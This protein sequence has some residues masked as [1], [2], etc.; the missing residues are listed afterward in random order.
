VESNTGS[1]II[2]V[3]Y[4]K[5]ELM[6]HYSTDQFVTYAVVDLDAI[7]HNVQALRKHVGPQVDIFA[8]V[9]AQAYGH[10]AVQVSRVAVENGADRL[11]VGRLDEGIELRQAGIHAL[12][13]VMSYAVPAETE[14]MVEHDLIPTINTAEGAQAYANRAAALGKTATI[15]VKVDTG[16]GRYGVMPE[17]VV[18]FLNYLSDLPGLV[19]EGL[20]THFATADATDK[21]YAHQQFARFLDIIEAVRLAG[22]NIPIYHSANSAG[23][24]DLPDM[25]LDAVRPGL[26]VYGMYPSVEVKRDVP[27]KPALSLKS[28]V[29]RVRTLPKGSSVGYGRTFVTSRPTPIAL[30]LV[31][32]GDGYHRILSNRGHVLIRGQR[33][34]IVG[35]VCMDQFMV[36]ASGIKGVTQDDEV[37]LL[38]E[39]GEAAITAEELA[40]LTETINYEVTTSILQRVPRIYIRD[41]QVVEIVRMIDATLQHHR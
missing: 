23:T 20:Y 17:E 35:R 28:H 34:P 13:L 27:L 18:P 31:G 10:G 25:H 11:A 4:D 14:I 9:K 41:G 40:A 21:T 32:Y 26:A 3:V 39:Q 8:V 6:N 7:A 38:G 15:H 22:Y 29:A 5:A 2:R 24:L 30:I 12:I 1:R 19:V 37:V 33:A 36:D 16:M